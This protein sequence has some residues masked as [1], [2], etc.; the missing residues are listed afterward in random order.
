MICLIFT[1]CRMVKEVRKA[2]AYHNSLTMHAG[3]STTEQQS[4]A[5]TNMLKTVLVVTGV[6][7]LSHAVGLGCYLGILIDSF[8]TPG[9]QLVQY[10]V[11]PLLCPIGGIVT[12]VN[13][14]VNVIIYC[15]FLKQFRDRWIQLW[16]CRGIEQ[17]SV[18]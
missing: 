6:F 1:S 16:K 18:V 8:S 17:N 12:A 2:T 3:H 11:S 7:I 9:L 13:S 14:S 15:L 10:N 4:P 5:A